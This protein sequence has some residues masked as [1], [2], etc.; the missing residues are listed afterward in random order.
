MTRLRTKSSRFVRVS[1][2]ERYGPVFNVWSDLGLREN[3]FK[4]AIV[5]GEIYSL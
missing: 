1:S 3:F 2:V 4:V 5:R